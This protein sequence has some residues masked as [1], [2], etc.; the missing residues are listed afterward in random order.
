VSVLEA[1]LAEFAPTGD[2]V[3]LA[4]GTGWWTERLATDAR[5]LTVV[6]S[7][8][9]TLELSRR[10]VH[11]VIKLFYEPAELSRVLAEEGWRAEIGGTRR[12]IY[13]SARPAG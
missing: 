6:D 3:E 12:F 1:A 9:E 2:V 4:G 5:S 11:R 8:P 10:R 13:G 7:S